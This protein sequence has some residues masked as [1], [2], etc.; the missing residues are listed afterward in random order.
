MKLEGRASA[1]ALSA[2]SLGAGPD[3]SE[4]VV[5]MLLLFYCLMA[6]CVQCGRQMPGLTF[7]KKICQWCKQHEAQQR[8][9]DVQ[10]QRVETAPWAR[11]QSSSMLVT[12]GIFGINVAVFLGM[13]LA[14]GGAMLSDPPGQALVHWGANFG[15]LTVGGQWWR[16]LTCLFVHAGLLHIGFNMWC[17]WDLGR[18]AESV[19][20]KWT[21]AVVYLLCG[22]SASI[23]SLIWNPLVLSVG[24]S[25]AIFGIAGA[26]ISSF[27]LGEFSLPRAAVSG[28]LRSV[29]AFVGYNLVFGAM[30]AH[31]DNAAHVGG[32][33]MGLILGALIAKIAPA[34]D[35]ILQRIGVLVFGAAL[36]AGGGLYLARSRAAY[37][38]HGANGVASLRK[39]DLDKGIQEL[40]M[41][42]KKQPSFAGTHEVLANAYLA[43]QDFDNAAA[44]L[45]RVIELDHSNE[46][47]YYRLGLVYLT[48]KQPVEAQ[49]VFNQ[50]LKINPSSANGH[51][52]LASAYS[53]EHRYEEAL[54]EYKRVAGIDSTYRD[55]YYN[56]GV[57]E[58]HLN[59]ADEAVAALLKQRETWD[60]VD[61]ETLLAAV[62]QAKGMSSE[63]EAA[64]A[65]AAELS[66]KK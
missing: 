16:L 38:V 21:F 12:Q 3:E 64:R 53:D 55:V 8:G 48:Q 11:P 54:A 35:A 47:A 59:Q 41:A 60:D 43:K 25:G 61:N 58:A 40:Q 13:T 20:G 49:E 15:P 32:L 2:A 46:D 31:V 23:G 51:A 4:L 66:G 52:G 65:K 30:I 57:V 62:Y 34:H 24:A 44:E 36:V 28:M 50:L 63:A 37:L 17:L 9:E 29:V 7:G 45:K 18:L 19:Y 39:G 27:Y 1:G 33:V 5:L 14:I 22:L 6:Q 56:I 26:L 10:Y 42:A